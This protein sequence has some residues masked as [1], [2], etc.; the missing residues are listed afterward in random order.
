[1]SRLGA[2]GLYVARPGK[3][4]CPR[5]EAAENGSAGRGETYRVHDYQNAERAQEEK[6]DDPRD[7]M[8][9]RFSHLPYP[10]QLSL[11]SRDQADRVSLFVDS[12]KPGLHAL[13][14][15]EKE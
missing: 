13:V 14:I 7:V 5:I 4:L 12:G 3:R 10:I 15:D 8:A 11:D 1:M 6:R 9:H 2:G